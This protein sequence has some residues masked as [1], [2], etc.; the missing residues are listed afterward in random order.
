M[1]FSEPPH[2]NCSC[3]AG[4]RPARLTPSPP[5]VCECV[6]GWL[7]DAKSPQCKRQCKCNATRFVD[8]TLLKKGLKKQDKGDG[9]SVTQAWCPR[10]TGVDIR[11]QLHR[12]SAF[13]LTLRG[14][15]RAALHHHGNSI[16]ADGTAGT[17]YGPA[18]PARPFH[19]ANIFPRS[20]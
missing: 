19:Y 2:P 1:P 7:Q 8:L 9:L 11:H 20:C 5:S 17:I 16:G 6:Y 3:R 10:V 13:Y 4:C 14:A 18:P 12:R 15:G